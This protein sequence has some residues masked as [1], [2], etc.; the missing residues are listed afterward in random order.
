MN[1]EKLLNR[2][3]KLE[4]QSRFLIGPVL[5]AVLI[6]FVCG[7]MPNKKQEQ[8]TDGRFRIVYASKFALVD[9]RTDTT[10]ATLAHQTSPNGWA[11]LHLYD[12]KGQPRVWI[13]LFE[14]G[15]ASIAFLDSGKK[16]QSEIRIDNKGLASSAMNQNEEWIYMREMRRKGVDV[17]CSG[18]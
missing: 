2:V 8:L 14:D 12:S 18:E 15:E 11:G 10:R 1:H 5:L 4:K 3:V 7:A 6:V 16:I 9:P 17:T 13:K